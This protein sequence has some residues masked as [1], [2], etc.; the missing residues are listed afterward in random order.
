MPPRKHDGDSNA[1]GFP[2]LPSHIKTVRVP[3]RHHPSCSR[4]D[5]IM[6]LAVANGIMRR[7]KQAVMDA[8]PH[9]N[10]PTRFEFDDHYTLHFHGGNLEMRRM[11]NNTLMIEI[12][13]SN[14]VGARFVSGSDYFIM[15]GGTHDTHFHRMIYEEYEEAELISHTIALMSMVIEPNREE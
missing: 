11:A 2:S 1:A 4:K 13:V 6:R 9:D 10:K 7:L 3:P 8:W 12:D 14:A 15:N 5:T